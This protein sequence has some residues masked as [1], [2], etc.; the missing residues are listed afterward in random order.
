MYYGEYPLAFAACTNQYD[1]YRLLLAKKADPNRQ[2]TN[3]NTVLHM[4][5][6]HENMEMLKL[7]YDTGGKLQI[8]NKQSLTPLTLAAKLAKKNVMRH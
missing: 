6:I 4:T 8:M 7:T 1:C 5:V 2:D 3:G